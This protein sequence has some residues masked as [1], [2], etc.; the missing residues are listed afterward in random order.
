MGISYET[1]TAIFVP[2]HCCHA[3]QVLMVTRRASNPEKRV[4]TSRSVRMTA[5]KVRQLTTR[6]DR[7][8]GEG[9]QV[10]KAF[11][12]GSVVRWNVRSA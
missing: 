1:P 12:R 9:V 3:G 2:E 6:E 4:R 11:S 8:S 10:K 7:V 5:Q